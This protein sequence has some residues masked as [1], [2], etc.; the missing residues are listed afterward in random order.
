MMRF[1][2][3]MT[4]VLV[5]V[6]GTRLR[7]NRRTESP[8]AADAGSAAVLQAATALATEPAK[9]Y[10]VPQVKKFVDHEISQA[11]DAAKDAIHFLQNQICS[12]HKAEPECTGVCSW[13]TVT[14]PVCKFAPPSASTAG[15]AVAATTM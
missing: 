2:L 11:M 8:A 13:H 6:S 5:A 1:I 7:H 3:S 15:S 14:P 4:I 12:M 9:V 10:T